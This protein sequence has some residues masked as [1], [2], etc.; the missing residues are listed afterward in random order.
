MSTIYTL[1]AAGQHQVSSFVKN[2][3]KTGLNAEAWFA[4][5]ELAANDAFDREIAAVIELGGRY[6]E[7]GR[8]EILV[9]EMA[10]FDADQADDE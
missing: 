8:P 3:G 7:S 9:L 10:W 5:A 2:H 6:T 4:E 1:N